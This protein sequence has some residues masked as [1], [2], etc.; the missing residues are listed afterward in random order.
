M[1]RVA[2]D[3]GIIKIYWY[4][5]CIF[6]GIIT[7]VTLIYRESKRRNID[8]DFLLNL[9]FYSIL[10]GILGA[11]IYYV[12]FNLNYY[13]ENP[14]EI[15]EIWNG[16]LAIHGGLL[17]GLVVISLY[18]KKNNVN[19]LKML[20]IIGVGVII[21]QA[22]GRWGNFFN[23]EAYGNI[24]S[25]AH[26]KSQ[27]IPKFIIDGMYI[28]GFYRQPTFLYESILCVTGF[29]IMLLVRKYKNL[30]VGQL[31][32]FY[33]IWY[34]MI[35]FIIE[36]MR[37]DSLMLGPIKIAQLISILFIVVGLII[38]IKSKNNMLYKS[39]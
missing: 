8:S 22:I 25:L 12:L 21:A 23:G 10:L 14:I 2:I 7:A 28:D 31:T 39:K 29:I 11:R 17:T 18:S 24:T 32:G 9:T 16:G 36:S 15:F 30:K 26:L 4:S 33:L 35:R 27:F 1:D 13:L 19:I 20:D 6:L 37:S 34:G 38:E 3:F 5:I